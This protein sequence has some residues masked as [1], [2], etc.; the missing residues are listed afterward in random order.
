[1]GPRTRCL[2]SDAPAARDFQA[3]L[4]PAPTTLPNFAD[5]Q[6]DIL[7]NM[8]KEQVILP[9]DDTKSYGP[10][11]VRLAWQCF[12]TFRQTDYQGGCNGAR[13]RFSPQIDWPANNYI[14]QAIDL[15][16][17]IKDKYSNKLTWADLIVLAGTTALNDAALKAGVT[18]NIPFI[19]GRSDASENEVYRTM[20]EQELRVQGGLDTDRSPRIRDIANIM[21]LTDR[22]FVAL[23]GGGHG[24]GR[25]HFARS[26]FTNGTWTTTPGLLNNEYFKTLQNQSLAWKQIGNSPVIHYEANVSATRKVHM[27]N[28]D[29]QFYYDPM[30]Q[31]IVQEYALDANTFYTDFA[32]AWYKIMTVD[33]Y[34]IDTTQ[35]VPTTPEQS[36]DEGLNDA[37]VIGVAVAIGFGV[38][39]LF[40]LGYF[41]YASKKNV[42]KSTSGSNVGVSI[43]NP[44]IV[45]QAK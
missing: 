6:R 39:L 44:V 1:M 19:G 21:G 28:A 24:L 43:Q 41:Y 3:P 31:A 38:P 30:Y 7:L 45:G 23:M 36:N 12:N 22:E 37:S 26:G 13:I 40:V 16:Q 15:L 14:N 20:W 4:P 27:L 5:V 33:M 8:Q 35:P 29:R 2:N 9:F 25:M 42:K 18:L 17:P 32:A 34:G 11:Y 10:L